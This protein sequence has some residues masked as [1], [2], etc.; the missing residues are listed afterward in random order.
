M[1]ISLRGVVTPTEH[2]PPWS[3]VLQAIVAIAVAV[4]LALL[5]T[6]LL[7]CLYVTLVS[8]RMRKV[9]EGVEAEANIAAAAAGRE[10]RGKA[11]EVGGES[12]DHW[13][14]CFVS[15]PDPSP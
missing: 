2:L 4:V 13:R 7:Y 3:P 5:L 8:R 9:N 12:G 15:F 11:V 10:G 14:E 6:L 1:G